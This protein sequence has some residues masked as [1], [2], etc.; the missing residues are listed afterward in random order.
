MESSILTNDLYKIIAFAFAFIML[1][2]QYYK[3]IKKVISDFN[4]LS[5]LK[6]VKRKPPVTH[7]LDTFSNQNL[8]DFYIGS[9]DFQFIIELKQ[10][11][12]L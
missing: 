10:C 6:L 12:S 1:T 3:K 7:S 4:K 9:S 2:L 11:K 5:F 8:I